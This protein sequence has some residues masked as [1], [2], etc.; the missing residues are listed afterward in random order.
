MTEPRS[1]CFS[2]TVKLPNLN[3]YILAERTNRYVAAEM[4]KKYTGICKMFALPLR[5]KLNKDKQHSLAIGWNL[6]NK[7]VDPDN[8][9]FAQKFILDGLVSAGVLANDGANQIGSIHHN[10]TY[11]G[12]YCI[13]VMLTE[14]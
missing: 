5:G 14:L 10:F 3:E 9:C 1:F 12:K 11:G 7:K 13:N 6:E 8:I 4:K 2:I